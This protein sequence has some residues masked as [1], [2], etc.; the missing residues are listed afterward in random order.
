MNLRH[1]KTCRSGLGL[2]ELMISLA[3]TASLLTATALAPSQPPAGRRRSVVSLMAMT[4]QS[5]APVSAGGSLAWRRFQA[6]RQ[7]GEQNRAC[8]RRGAND[9]PHCSQFRVSATSQCYA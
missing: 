3:I 7:R 9:V 8:S 5:S 1:Y 2:V 4:D 6:T